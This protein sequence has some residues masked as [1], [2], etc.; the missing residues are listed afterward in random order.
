MR[1]SWGAPRRL[2]MTSK[3]RRRD[4]AVELARKDEY[5]HVVVNE[6]DRIDETAEQIDAIIAAEHERFADRRIRV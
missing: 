5:D 1:G 6:T 4:A 3:I 2:R